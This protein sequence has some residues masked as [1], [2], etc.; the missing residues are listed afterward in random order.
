MLFRSFCVLTRERAQLYARIDARVEQMFIAGWITEVQKLDR[1]WYPFLLEKKL[2]GY[3]D[4]INFLS[5]LD[6]INPDTKNLESLIAC[7]AHKTRAYAKR[8]LTF[9][10]MMTKKVEEHPDS[11]YTEWVNVPETAT[12]DAVAQTLYAII[13]E[14]GFDCVGERFKK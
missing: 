2:I 14:K 1:K 3:D 9:N 5:N 11:V 10:R 6:L 4:I 13:K 7:I 8:Q 12:D